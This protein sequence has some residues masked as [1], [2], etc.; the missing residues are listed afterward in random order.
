MASSDY[1]V[2]ASCKPFIYHKYTFSNVYVHITLKIPVL[3]RSPKSSSVEPGQ[4]LNG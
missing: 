4:Y 3:V 2:I 1:D